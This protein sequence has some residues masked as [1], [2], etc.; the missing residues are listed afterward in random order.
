VW[1]LWKEGKPED[2]IDPAVKN[3]PCCNPI[4]AVKFIHVGLLCVQDS[5]TN[6]PTMSS[7]TLML[8]SNDSQPFPSPGEPAF[9]T[10]R[11][12]PYCRS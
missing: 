3:K 12:R 6:R 8:S 2:L 1:E 10:R 5:P 4:E 7:V 9:I 11:A